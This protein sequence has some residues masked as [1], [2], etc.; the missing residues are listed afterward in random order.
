[1]D[2]RRSFPLQREELNHNLIGFQKKKK[3]LYWN[4]FIRLGVTVEQKDIQTLA[5]G[6]E[7]IEVIIVK[8]S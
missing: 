4:R 5:E 7:I 3:K 1:M 8:H 2:F 6:H